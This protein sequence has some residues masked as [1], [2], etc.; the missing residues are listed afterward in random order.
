MSQEKEPLTDA[1]KKLLRQPIAR[2]FITLYDDGDCSLYY[3]QTF[4]RV[5]ASEIADRAA[6][7]LRKW[8]KTI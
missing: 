1:E 5:R 3:S 8:R 7:A 6:A 2:V 4:E